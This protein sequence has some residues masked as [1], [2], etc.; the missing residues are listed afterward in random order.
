MSAGTGAASAVPRG[1]VLGLHVGSVMGT[2]VSKS[3]PA[4]ILRAT[5]GSGPLLQRD[6][7]AVIDGSR[8]GPTQIASAVARSFP[9]FPPPDLVEFRRVGGADAPLEVGDEMTV[10]IRM[11]GTFRVRVVHRNR[12]SITIATLRGHPEAGRITFGAYRNRRGDVIF[13]IRSRARSGSPFHRAGFLGIGDPMQTY[14]WTDFVNAVAF[15]FGRGVV[16]FVYAET[17]KIRDEPDVALDG[18][19]YVAEGD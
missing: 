5:R 6:Y 19:T 7:W 3:E 18:P 9:S 15:Q 1:P 16:G 13:H 11:A 14:T 10:R 12:N 2:L 17:S 8:A 4:E